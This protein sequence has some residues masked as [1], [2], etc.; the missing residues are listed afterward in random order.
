MGKNN[1]FKLIKGLLAGLAPTKR[2][3]VSEWADNHRFLAEGASAQPGRWRTSRTPYL[4]EIMDCLSARSPIQEVVFMKGAQVGGTEAAYNFIGYLIDIDPCSIL[5]VMPTTDNLKKNSR[6]RLDPMI[7][8]SPTLREKVPPAKS[9]SGDNSMFHKSFPGGQLQMAGANSATGLRSM[10]IRALILDEVDG[11]PLDIDGEGSPVELAEA[12]TRTFAATKKILKISTPTLKGESVITREFEDSDQRFYHVP[13]P[14]CG[15]KQP[16]VFENLSWPEGEPHLA[17]YHCAECGAGIEERHKTKMLA[18]GE[19]R[20]TNQANA[21]RF[22]KKRGYHLNSLYSPYGW[23]SWAEIAAKYEAARKH[24]NLMQPFVNTM[25][26]LPYE[27]K[28]EKPEWQ[29]L[30][31]RRG[32]YEKCVP[33]ND[34]ALITAGVDVQENRI[35]LEIVGWAKGK[36]SYSLDYRVLRGD[37]AQPDVWAQLADVLD[38][39]FVREDGA[40]MKIAAMGI[41]TGFQTS[42]VYEF[43]R[44]QPAG[45]V[46]CLKGMSAQSTI[47]SSP[48]QTDVTKDGKRVGSVFL[49]LVGV[50]V[51]KSELY[52][53]LRLEIDTDGSA[54]DGY[55]YFPDYTEAYF[56]GLTSEELRARIV[57]GYTVYEWK[58]IYRRNEPLDCRNYARATAAILQID[59][60]T[61]ARWDQLRAAPVSTDKTAQKTPKPKK[62]SSYWQR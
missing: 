36:V 49:Y 60:F 45:R 62:E 51:L 40:L 22:P 43:C 29:E 56:E 54:P 47:I 25:L 10:P 31:A 52:A 23:L 2:V 59:R 57:N 16:L 17:Q 35:E 6:T 18:A 14:H 24:D 41:D 9:R 32:G 37:T 42:R 33:P 3:N 30:F 44:A 48:R 58:K 50:S 12:R 27:V 1:D 26:G 21:E 34:V 13:C 8:A 19:W 38:E 4:K 11:F 61:P 15:H 55:C 20:A 46:F 5:L 28:G 7:A 53:N 39:V